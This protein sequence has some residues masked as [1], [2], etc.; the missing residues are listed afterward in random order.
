MKRIR[1]HDC[2]HHDGKKCTA[3]IPMWVATLSSPIIDGKIISSKCPAFTE[4]TRARCLDC[5]GLGLEPTHE[6]ERCKRCGGKGTEPE[7]PSR[8]REG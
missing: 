8:A 5:G 3:P 2:R 7:K 4:P 6:R 1:C